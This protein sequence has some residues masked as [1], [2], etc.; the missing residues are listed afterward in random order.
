VTEVKRVLVDV[1][2]LLKTNVTT[3]MSYKY[4]A[5]LGATPEL[6]TKRITYYQGLIG[7]LRWIVELGRINTMVAVAILSSHLMAPRQGHLE[8]CFHIFAYL[9]SHERFY[10][11]F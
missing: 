6:D 4:R 11:G 2:Q 1:N 7:V 9:D 8:K 3:P 10:S 5:K